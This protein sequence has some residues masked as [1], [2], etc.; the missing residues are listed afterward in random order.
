M[1]TPLTP[2]R[3]LGSVHV[4]HLEQQWVATGNETTIVHIV[5]YTSTRVK[6]LGK[7]RHLL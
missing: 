2:L 7:F 4:A 3:D 6:P 1:S 5:D